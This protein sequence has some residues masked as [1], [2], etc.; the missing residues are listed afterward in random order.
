MQPIELIWTQSPTQQQDSN[1][2]RA[3]READ[4]HHSLEQQRGHSAEAFTTASERSVSDQMSSE[5]MAVENSALNT[6]LPHP[7]SQPQASKPTAAPACERALP[8]A[9]DINTQALRVEEVPEVPQAPPA[10][11]S[12]PNTH[13]V[14]SIEGFKPTYHNSNWLNTIEVIHMMNT[15]E[16]EHFRG[17]EPTSC[18]NYTLDV[19]EYE[20]LLHFQLRCARRHR[21]SIT[22]VHQYLWQCQNKQEVGILLE[23]SSW[24]NE[25][26]QYRLETLTA[27]QKFN[28][29]PDTGA[30]ER[31]HANSE[32]RGRVVRDCWRE[33]VKSSHKFHR[34]GLSVEW[35][36]LLE[37][38]SRVEKWA[39]RECCLGNN[40]DKHILRKRYYDLVGH[41]IQ[42]WSTPKGYLEEVQAVYPKVG[43]KAKVRTSVHD[44]PYK[45]EKLDRLRI[46]EEWKTS[47]GWKC[48]AATSD[49]G[50]YSTGDG[51]YT[52]KRVERGHLG[53]KFGDCVPAGGKK[54]D[55]SAAG[56]NV[57]NQCSGK[58]KRRD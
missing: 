3:A 25:V 50:S 22:D 16:R 6:L 7:P 23:G 15:W 51:P 42:Q 40:Y 47:R 4:A 12:A 5:S 46:P 30:A 32:I 18:Y 8:R 24:R 31:G 39:F 52:I 45:Q 54:H 29:I 14:Y 38:A 37:L 21:G 48:K 44:D 2:H 57:R 27:A 34:M 20:K 33:L 43:I 26:F 49:M 17:V 10:P 1:T 35:H 56:L 36:L 41:K 58:Q 55:S 19:H 13:P 53:E 9:N 11:V 28:I